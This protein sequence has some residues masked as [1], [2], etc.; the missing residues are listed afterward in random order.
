MAALLLFQE[1]ARQETATAELAREV[2]ASLTR[3][4]GGT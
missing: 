2:A 3:A 1:A 4:R